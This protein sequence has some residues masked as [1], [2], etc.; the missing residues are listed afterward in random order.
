MFARHACIPACVALA[1][2]LLTSLPTSA[3]EA[4]RPVTVLRLSRGALQGIQH[5]SFET[6]QEVN[7]LVLGTTIKGT[8]KTTAK[9]ALQPCEAETSHGLRIVISGISVTNSEG[10]NGP[11]IIDSTTTTQ[12]TAVAPLLFD[13]AKGITAGEI[14]V[15]ADTETKTNDIRSTQ[16]GIAGTVVKKLAAKKIEQSREEARGIAKELAVKRITRAIREE[17]AAR[18]AAINRRY[19]ELQPIVAQ[20]H[21]RHD[22]TPA[23]VSHEGNL[24]ICLGTKVDPQS[25]VALALVGE[26]DLLVH[27]KGLSDDVSARLAKLSLPTYSVATTDAAGVQPSKID[28]ANRQ[29]DWLIVTAKEVRK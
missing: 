9:C 5:Q 15:E 16:G 18:V 19:E 28:V 4:S 26:M 27:A 13:A 3:D 22:V 23:L 20:L 10:R 7:D 6:E 29:T 2:S 21:E 1:A 25:L 14:T 24:F 12:F 8:A 17:V 11:A